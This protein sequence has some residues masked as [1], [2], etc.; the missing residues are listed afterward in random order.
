MNGVVSS[1]GFTLMEVLVVMVITSL[2]SV[3]LVQGFSLVLA[4]R[5]SVQNKIVGLERIVMERNIY[6]D[7]VRGILPDYK[8]RPNTFTGEARKLKGLTIRPLNGRMGTPVGFTLALDY[9]S[10]RNQMVLIYQEQG[11]DAQEIGRWEGQTGNFAYRDLKG[12]WLEE[13]PPEDPTAQQTPWLVRLTMGEEFPSMLMASI[14][15][16]HQ[17]YV[18]IQDTPMGVSTP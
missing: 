7:P 11:F 16:S 9:D 3:V 6:L 14:I 17:R 18:R 1:R 10:A 2:I 13:W 12:D 5:T 15:G 8:D 4:A